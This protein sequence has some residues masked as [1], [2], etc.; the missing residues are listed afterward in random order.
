MDTL[1]VPG[2]DPCTAAGLQ[3]RIEASRAGR[4]LISVVLVATVSGIVVANLPDSEAQRQLAEVSRPYMNATGL[5][6]R[7]DMFS[8]PRTEVL[9]LEARVE[10]ADGS[11]TTWR[12]PTG[13]PLIA[14]Y[15]DTHWRKYVEHAVARPG[16]GDG[17]P[18]LWAPL[19]RY[20]AAQAP[21]DSPPMQVTLVKR[22]ALT[23]PPG[24]GPEQTPFREESYFT[25]RLQ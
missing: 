24:D 5:G 18:A 22:S 9:Y 25:L 16:N 6:Q 13:E 17:W 20:V 12:P 1:T 23:L 3:Q 10:H 8:N 2:T 4:W 19:A 11:L 14:G 7:W 15:R 21:G